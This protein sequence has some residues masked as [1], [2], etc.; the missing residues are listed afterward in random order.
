MY[1]IPERSHICSFIKKNYV[2]AVASNSC[3]RNIMPDMRRNNP[4]LIKIKFIQ[5]IKDYSSPLNH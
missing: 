1:M 3:L 2:K 4:D 5:K